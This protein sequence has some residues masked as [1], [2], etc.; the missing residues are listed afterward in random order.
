[1]TRAKSLVYILRYV[2][3]CCRHV[4][5]NLPTHS[6]ICIYFGSAFDGGFDQTKDMRSRFP[7]QAT[8]SGIAVGVNRI[9]SLCTL[10]LQLNGEWT[11]EI[12]IFITWSQ[13]R[14]HNQRRTWC[15]GI[16]LGKFLYCAD[17]NWKQV[18]RRHSKF[19]KTQRVVISVNQ[20]AEHWSGDVC[21]QKNN[22]A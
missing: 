8:P 9:L 3:H 13:N 18:Y 6:L 10:S 17:D 2:K 11:A 16:T 19:G 12:Y 4:D 22:S 15:E 5:K 14:E 1:M 21:S 20:R 7:R